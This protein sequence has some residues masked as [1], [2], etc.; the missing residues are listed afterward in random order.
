M[1]KR[2]DDPEY[3]SLQSFFF[4]VFVTLI[5][6]SILFSQWIPYVVSFGWEGNLHSCAKYDDGCSYNLVTENNATYHN[7]HQG[8]WGYDYEDTKAFYENEACQVYID[9]ARAVFDAECVSLSLFVLSAASIPWC[10]VSENHIFSFEAKALWAFGLVAC[11]T[12]VTLVTIVLDLY[13]F[14]DLGIDDECRMGQVLPPNYNF[15][16]V[17]ITM[18]TILLVLNC[19]FNTCPRFNYLPDNTAN[20]ALRTITWMVTLFY[21]IEATIMINRSTIIDTRITSAYDYQDCK[22]T[23]HNDYTVDD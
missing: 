12:L 16:I 8:G 1:Y 7:C 23:Q 2:Y 21:F 9:G 3:G 15:R 22:V 6:T 10:R 20:A 17:S 5:V 13:H 14:G 19:I 18:A 11:H 4:L